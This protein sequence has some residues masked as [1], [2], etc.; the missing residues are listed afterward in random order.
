MALIFD[1][2]K[3]YM[4]P[5]TLGAPDNLEDAIID[6]IE[7]AS[8]PKDK[9]LIAVQELE[10]EPITRAIIAAK[11]R[12]VTVRIVL[13]GDYLRAKT[14]RAEPFEPVGANEPNRL[15]L[16]AL[17][18]AGI[19]VRTDY[20]PK[21]FHQ[22]FIVRNRGRGD[23][24]VLTGST[25][26]TPTGTHENLNHIVVFEGRRIASEY[27]KEF[28]EIWEGTFGE[29]RSRHE[30]AP[31]DGTVSNVSYRLAFAPDHAPEME[32]MKQMLKARETIDFAIFTFANSSGIDDA[33]IAMARA[34][35]KIRGVMDR[36]QGAQKWA[37]TEA[38]KAAGADIRGA[39]KGKLFANG[40]R[41][42]KLHHKLM[43]IDHR[44]VIGGSFNYTG[45]A[46]Q[47]ND[48]NIFILGDLENETPAVVEREREVGAFVL[49]EIDRI[50]Q[51]FGEPL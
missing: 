9:L 26:F 20:N 12:K 47:L 6:F 38:I 51:T 41:M 49:H 46:N 50:F 22:K 10:S 30:Q 45:P 39:P 3:L 17:F 4:G 48:E 37:A 31:K 13:E 28:S 34:G 24:A 8:K 2:L 36:T 14:G 15:M 18:R 40:H 7:G 27:E 16:S 5:H 43:L 35:V 33:M 42:N 32:I 21:I 25:N 29:K 19:D 44:V 1:S 23:M 11:Q